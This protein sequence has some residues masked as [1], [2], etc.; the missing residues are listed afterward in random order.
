MKKGRQFIVPLVFL[1][2]SIAGIQA[3]GL[4]LAYM[5]GEVY[6]RIVRNG[7]MVLALLIPIMAGMGINFAIS[8]GAISAQVGLILALDFQVPGL[9]G[10]LFALTVGLILSY[11]SGCMIAWV[12]NRAK[13]KE[14]ICGIVMSFLAT[15]LYHLVFMVGYGTVIPVR[16][17]QLV[18]SKGV[19]LRN[20]LDTVMYKNLFDSVLTLHTVRGSY[21]MVPFIIIGV[22]AVFIAYVRRTPLGYRF[23][24]VGESLDIAEK[25]GI[26][27]DETRKKAIV[28]STMMAS[29]GHLL[30]I[31]NMGVVNVYTGHL[32]VNIFAAAA[33][34]AGGATLK[35]ATITQA[36]QGLI[37][38]H[39]L[40]IVSPMAGQN[41]FANAALGEY[42]RSFIAYGTIVFALMMSLKQQEGELV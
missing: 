34:M 28:L 4:S 18:L 42:F 9:A 23:R 6:A 30:F 33:L 25:L 3:A 13:G 5:G 36:F 12:Y 7:V 14:M 8:I 15:N 39:T 10:L 17:S 11:F 27:I 22:V 26:D 2:L 41:L 1:I 16:N 24:V 20:M 19:G 21:S 31:Q 40:F 37:L 32:N 35:R 29:L 38:F